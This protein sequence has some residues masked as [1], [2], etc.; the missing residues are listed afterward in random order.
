MLP[1][2]HLAAFHGDDLGADQGE[3]TG[4]GRVRHRDLKL[5]FGLL[6]AGG[7]HQDEAIRR[8]SVAPQSD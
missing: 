8:K 1:L 2:D 3:A 7:A 6:A 4:R 5:G